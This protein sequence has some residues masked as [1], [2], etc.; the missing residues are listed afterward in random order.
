MLSSMGDN[1]RVAIIG[2]S[3]GIGS[4]F[5]RQFE[6]SDQTAHIYALSRQSQNY[7]AAKITSLVFDFT[8][9]NSVQ[10]CAAHIEQDGP[11][12]LVIIATG[13]LHDEVTSPEKNMRAL[14]F[15]NFEKNFAINTFGPAITAK[16]FLPIMRRD[17]KA[18]FSALSAR[19]GSISDN[20]LG[21]W[22]SYRASKAALNMIFKTLSIEYAR[23]FKNIIITGLHPG[24]VDT[25]LSQPFQNNVAEGKLFTPEYSA[26]KLLS[27]I[28]QISFEDS[29]KT[30][31]WAGEIIP[32]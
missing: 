4:A 8:D 21:G 11:L 5:I 19:V 15:N 9:E 25:K 14:S 12:D 27:V 7:D 17:S 20:R 18:V 10:N 32:C 26:E 1:L 16:Y 29:G 23:R 13:F 28:D 30:F 24:T 3:G 31:D 6:A 2:A 22:Y